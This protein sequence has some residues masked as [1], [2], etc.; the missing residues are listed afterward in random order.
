M[1]VR[2]VATCRAG[3]SR[4]AAAYGASAVE[5]VGAGRPERAAGG[6]AVPIEARVI[7]PLRDGFEV[8]QARVTCT[9]DARGAVAAL[10]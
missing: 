4:A 2:A 6:L 7:Y 5:A 8:R 10:T 9:I 1:P 3:L